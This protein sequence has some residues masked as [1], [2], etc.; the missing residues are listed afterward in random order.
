[1]G[2]YKH[3]NLVDGF[4]YAIDCPSDFRIHHIQFFVDHGSVE[5]FL[6]FKKMIQGAD[7]ETGRI[8]YF[9]HR[10]I[11]KSLCD[12]YPFRLMKDFIPPQLKFHLFSF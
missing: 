11:V 12:K 9:S 10:R 5:L 1:M 3:L 8:R 7:G 4:F 6:A 2:S